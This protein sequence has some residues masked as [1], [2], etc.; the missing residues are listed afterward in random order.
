MSDT[1]N[2]NGMAQ[3]LPNSNGAPTSHEPV[4]TDSGTAAPAAEGEQETQVPGW[5]DSHPEVAPAEITWDG[6]ARVYTWDDEYGDVGPKFEDLERE[7]F[8]DPKDLNSLTGL[9]FSKYAP[10][11]PLPIQIC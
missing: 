8:G 10:C 11:L 1:W 9:D 5:V 4:A 6:D 2:T 7:L 3:A